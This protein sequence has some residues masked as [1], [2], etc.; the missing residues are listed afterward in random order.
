MKQTNL[1]MEWN[2]EDPRNKNLESHIK[3]RNKKTL[4]TKGHPRRVA[5]DKE[6]QGEI[7]FG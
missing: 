3:I 6:G 4:E 1:K 5:C 7:G 2:S